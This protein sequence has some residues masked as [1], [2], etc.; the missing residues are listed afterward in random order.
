LVEV[1]AEIITSM[2]G[3]DCSVGLCGLDSC[4]ELSDL[5]ASVNSFMARNYLDVVMCLSVHSNIVFKSKMVLLC[6]VESCIHRCFSSSTKDV[7]QLGNTQ[8]LVSLQSQKSVLA[9][10]RA[11]KCLDPSI[12][13]CVINNATKNLPNMCIAIGIRSGRCMWGTRYHLKGLRVVSSSRVW[14]QE[15]PLPH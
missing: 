1:R 13:I 8:V 9:I 15:K 5:C 2:N 6:S 3:S 10:L 4:Q 12:C 11:S 7:V 14:E